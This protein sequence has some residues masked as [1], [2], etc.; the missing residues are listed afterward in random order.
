MKLGLSILR[1]SILS[2]SLSYQT[3]KIKKIFKSYEKKEE[4]HAYFMPI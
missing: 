4:K 2:S 3:T 1:E